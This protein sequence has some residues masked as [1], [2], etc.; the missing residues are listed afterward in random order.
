MTDTRT[1][2]IGKDKTTSLLE[3][4]NLTVTFDSGTNL[5]GTGS[6]SELGL[7]L[8]TVRGSLTG[9]RSRTG[10]VLVRRVGARTDEGNLEFLGPVV[11]DDFLLELGDGGS[12][13]GSEG[14]VDVGLELGEVLHDEEKVSGHELRT[15]ERMGRTMSM[16]WS[17]SA[18]SSA[19]KL[20]ANR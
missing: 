9:D 12:Q 1:A 11:F 3:S 17:Y 14:T 13:V 19:F 2:S 16:T 20:C 18:F 10:H 4:S 5:L 15:T 6:D 8:E 7:G